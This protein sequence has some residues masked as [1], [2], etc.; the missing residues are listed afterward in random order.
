MECSQLEKAETWMEQMKKDVRRLKVYMGLL[1]FTQVYSGFLHKGSLL[2]VQGM[3][4][5]VSYNT[6]IK[7]QLQARC[8]L[9]GSAWKLLRGWQHA[10]GQVP[11]GGDEGQKRIEKSLKHLKRC[12]SGR[13]IATA[14]CPSDL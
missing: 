7:A 9:L 10:K 8:L 11:R 14:G 12:L 13:A 4:D 1:K 2:R 6:L 3:S 5:V